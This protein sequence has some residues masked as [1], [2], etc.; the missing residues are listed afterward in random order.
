M[1]AEFPEQQP[2]LNYLTEGG[3]ETELCTNTGLTSAPRHVPVARRLARDE[4]T[5]GNVWPISRYRRPARFRRGR[6]RTRLR[7]EPGLGV[8]AGL[9]P[10][11]IVRHELRAIDFLREVARPYEGQVPAIM[12]AGII[13]PRGDAYETNQTITAEEAEEYHSEQLATLTR[14]GVD[15]AEAMTF[16]TVPEVI[17]L[18]R[19]SARTGFRYAVLFTLNNSTQPTG[20]RAVEGRDRDHRRAGWGDRPASTASTSRTR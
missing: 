2:G 6:W 15:L 18:A 19:A 9:L 10:R 13:G 5:A 3:Q 11:S 7:G 14:A 12:Y 8:A 20:F 17:G 4:R 1:A 16:N